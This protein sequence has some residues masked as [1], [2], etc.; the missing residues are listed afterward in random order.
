MAV[1]VLVLTAIIA[2]FT[3]LLFLDTMPA[4]Q[5]PLFTDASEIL[6]V[7]A[8]CLFSFWLGSRLTRW[9]SEP[10]RAGTSPPNQPLTVKIG[11]RTLLASGLYKLEDLPH[12]DEIMQYS[13]HSVYFAGGNLDGLVNS[14]AAQIREHAGKLKMR[15]LFVDPTSPMGKAMEAYAD[16]VKNIH[17]QTDRAISTLLGIR[18]KTLPEAR[19]NEFEIRAHNGLPFSMILVDIEDRENSVIQIGYYAHMSASSYRPC[20]LVSPKS[21]IYD[22]LLKEFNAK[23]EHGGEGG[24]PHNYI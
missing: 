24:L 22:I 4:S 23:W 16:P 12:P 8:A 14:Y 2:T 10:I 19:R 7:I 1:A 17:G 9:S 18:D 11:G 13:K 15:F 20:A 21:E 3:A 5:R 6:I